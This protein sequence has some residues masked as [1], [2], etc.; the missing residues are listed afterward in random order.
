MKIPDVALMSFEGLMAKKFR[1]ALN[2]VG[3]LIGVA[4]ITGLIALTQ[5]LNNEISGQLGGLGGNTITVVAGGRFGP[6]SRS[7]PTEQN[8]VT[9]S[10]DWREIDIIE[11]LPG[12][13]LIA[14]TVSGGG[15]WFSLK[16][17]IYTVSI[18]GVTE[19]YFLINEGTKI[20]SGRTIKRSDD[21]VAIIGY[22][23]SVPDPNNKPLVEI[24]D[25]ITIQAEVKGEIKEL[26]VR[27][28]GVLEETGGT[29]GGDTDFFIPLKT[30]EQFFETEGVYDS[31][32]VLVK[33]SDI[34]DPLAALIE[35]KIDGVTAMTATGTME[36]INSVIG[37]LEAVLGGIAAISLLVAGVGIVNTMIVSVMERTKEIGTLKA[38]GAKSVDILVMFIF[39]AAL[40]G[41]VGGAIGAIL[42]FILGVVIG[43][44][45]GV[46]VVP[47]VELGLIAVLF[48]VITSVISGIYPAWNASKLNP[49]EAL[50][51]E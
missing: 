47:T 21:A 27:V 24:G 41:V 22:S 34:V 11:K 23:I 44:Y 30:C 16:G 38:I 51:H 18:T 19:T 9:A 31:I 6:H 35:S 14:Q 32:Q 17:D 45:V 28:I 48:A 13:D 1:F 25:R 26:T 12:V 50:R 5:G 43:S 10:L 33:D 4:A 40:T 20:E 36:T 3:I 7:G 46:G 8:A 15:A 2:L 42:G 37:T 29:F 39:E 49:V